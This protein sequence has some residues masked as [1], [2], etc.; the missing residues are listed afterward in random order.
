MIMKFFSKI[1]IFLLCAVIFMSAFVVFAEGHNNET[2]VWPYL[3]FNINV[4]E[5]NRIKD[6]SEDRLKAKISD[7]VSA[8]FFALTRDYPELTMWCTGFKLGSS[9]ALMP[10]DKNYV[11][12]SVEYMLNGNPSYGD[13]S[14]MIGQLNAVIDAFTPTGETMYDKLLS[15]HDYICQINTYVKGTPYCYSAYG[16]L[17]DGRSVCEGY[18][19][20]FKLLC[21]KAGIDCILVT[22]LALPD[23]NDDTKEAHMWNFV[24]MDDGEWYAVDAT[25]DDSGDISGNYK[26]FLVGSETIIR[27][28]KFKD[29]HLTCYDFIEIGGAGKTLSS[30]E[31]PTLAEVA[32]NKENG[33]ADYIYGGEKFH[34]SFLDDLQKELYDKILAEL[35][36]NMPSDP[37]QNPNIDTTDSTET[38]TPEETTDPSETT[39]E[40]TTTV[41]DTTV[42]ESTTPDQTTTPEDTSDLPTDTTAETTTTVPDYT[43][44]STTEPPVSSTQKDTK[45]PKPDTTTKTDTT[46]KD[47]EGNATSKTDTTANITTGKN[48]TSKYR[49]MYDLYKTVTTVVIICAISSLSIILVVM[50]IR[51][52]KKHKDS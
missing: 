6:S 33:R 18:A 36:S 8:P 14:G 41:T 11:L 23:E 30:L 20:A 26:Y 35:R 47:T 2:P 1:S 15:I 5:K 21:D 24:R 39:P 38:T 19:E 31:Y 28:R 32:Y 7:A 34:Y 46:E 48:K 37:T 4:T 12:M 27:G 42:A 13:P 29:S 51:Y 3:H 25:W 49:Q 52:A 40:E 44:P 16:A 9:Y 10:G 17:V 43:T 50:V 45:P 22:G